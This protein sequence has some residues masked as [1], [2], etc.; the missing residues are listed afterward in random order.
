M[1]KVMKM[2]KTRK[3]GNREKKGDRSRVCW[4]E[5]G[6]ERERSSGP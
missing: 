5:R 3:E 6:G 1:I 2:I 4:E